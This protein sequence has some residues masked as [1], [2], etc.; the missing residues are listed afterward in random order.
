MER[1]PPLNAIRVFE[2]AGRHLSFIR[3]ADELHITPSAVSHQIRLLEERLGVKLFRRL[4]RQVVLTPEGQS[5]L[6]PVRAALEQIGTATARV[7]GRCARGPLTISVA[8][9]FA[10]RW[11]VPRLPDFQH[12]HPEI[13]VRPIVSTEV[14]DLRRSD[15]DVAIRSGRGGWPGLAAHRL[16]GEE[17]VPV[18]SPAL[19]EGPKPLR[20]PEDLAGHTLLQVVPRAGEW[21]SWLSAVGVTGVDAD[22]GPRFQSLSDAIDAAALGLGVVIVNLVLIGGDLESGRL[23]R[24]FTFELPSDTAYYFVCQDERSE[25]PRIAAFREWL[26]EVLATDAGAEPAEPAA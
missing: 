21:R 18:C 6:L 25:E 26:L 5:Y 12:Q 11:L 10:V 20:R 23:V 19:L 13:E 3:A 22:A 8:P 16:M 4:N 14:A 7:T 1:L 15:V 17:L 2:A 24:P 9:S